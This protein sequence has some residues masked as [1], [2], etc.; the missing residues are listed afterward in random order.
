MGPRTGRDPTTRT[1]CCGI[2][3]ECASRCVVWSSFCIR[4]AAHIVHDLCG[5]GKESLQALFSPLYLAH[6]RYR[7][8]LFPPPPV[9][10][11]AGDADDRSR[12]DKAPKGELPDPDWDAQWHAASAGLWKSI[13]ALFRR[14]LSGTVAP[15]I[16][17]DVIDARRET[18][19]TPLAR[20]HED[21]ALEFVDPLRPAWDLR[22]SI[23]ARQAQRVRHEQELVHFS[24]PT[25]LISLRAVPPI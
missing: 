16:G 19:I 3:S 13:G 25:K 24:M 22:L 1:T 7:A 15:V 20:V 9:A 11:K 10:P 18:G 12:S 23:L 4:G 14:L 5:Q 2:W 21:L 17:T 6:A 8:K